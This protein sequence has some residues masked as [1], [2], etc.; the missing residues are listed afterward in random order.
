MQWNFP[1]LDANV[2][3]DVTRGFGVN[4]VMRLLHRPGQDASVELARTARRAIS[5]CATA[6]V[7][8]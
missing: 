2:K 1:T 3:A 6:N 8:V 4:I 5:S 7:D